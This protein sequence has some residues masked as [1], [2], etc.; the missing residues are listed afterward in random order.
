MLINGN[1]IISVI[2][3]IDSAEKVIKYIRGYSEET[4]IKNEKTID[5]ITFQLYM[6][7][8]EANGI[9]TEFK[10][11][12]DQVDWLFFSFLSVG[13][14][15]SFSDEEIWEIIYGIDDFCLSVQLKK[16]RTVL[17]ALNKYINSSE[18]LNHILTVKE[19]TEWKNREGYIYYSTWIDGVKRKF[20]CNTE[21][22]KPNNE[23][24]IQALK[25]LTNKEISYINEDRFTILQYSVATKLAIANICGN[26]DYKKT[27]LEDYIEMKERSVKWRQEKELPWDTDFPY[28]IKTKKSIWTVKKK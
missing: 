13:N 22:K 18:F 1:D 24:L 26:T 12:F 5:A 17:K 8:V 27:I 15:P 11:L 16:I 25:Q 2:N 3:I 4:L 9:T 23:E 7:G 14:I 21:K 10:K 20:E 6:I 28:P 19:F